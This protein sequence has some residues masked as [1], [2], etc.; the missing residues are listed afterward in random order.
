MLR[1]PC[2]PIGPETDLR[3]RVS[4]SLATLFGL[5][6]F[7]RGDIT[8]Q[9]FPWP[10]YAIGWDYKYGMHGTCIRP[11]P[12]GVWRALC[13]ELNLGFWVGQ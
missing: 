6:G 1:T 13:W 3:R 9:A 12:L 4:F 5:R 11:A 2:L 7:V 10:I 8:S